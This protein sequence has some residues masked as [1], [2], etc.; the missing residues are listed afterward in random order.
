MAKYTKNDLIFLPLGGSGEIGMNVNL[1]HFKGQWIMCDLG[2]GF[3]DDRHPGVDLVVANINFVKSLGEHFLGLVCTHAHED[4]IGGIPYLWD[5]LECPIYATPF[6][7]SMVRSKLHETGLER[8]AKVT[9]VQPG[10][11]FELGP[12]N[13]ELVQIT[14]SIPE[15]NGIIIKTELGTV[16]HTGDWKLDPEPV[17]GP[18]T[19]E[20]RLKQCGDEGVLAMICDSTNIFREGTSGSESGLMAGLSGLI[21]E[22]GKGLVVVATFASNV[23][24]LDTIARAAEANGRKV[25]L[26]GRSLW[27]VYAAARENGY[28]TDLEPFLDDRQAVKVP[29]HK[30]L[31]ISTG[32][33]GEE[34]AATAKLAYGK[35]PGLRLNK[36]DTVIFSS[37]VIPGNEKKIIH[38]LNE[39]VKQRVEVYTEK[40]HFVHVSGH[41]CRDEVRRMYELVRPQ[42]AVPVHGEAMHLHEH[43]KFAKSLGVPQ[44]VEV[45]NGAMVRLAPGNAEIIQHIENGIWM[46]DGQRLVDPESKVMKARR[47]MQRSGAAFVTV[48]LTKRGK[49]VTEPQI[50]VPGLLDYDENRALLW[51]LSEELADVVDSQRQTS[52]DAIVR[53]TR[54][55][56]RKAL[57]QET[58]KEPLIEVHVVVC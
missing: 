9:E 58:G 53:A 26:A 34:Q 20:A 4:H 16:L 57:K 39:F 38:L 1:Y 17:I 14:H 32:C 49:L 37:K 15:M 51:E 19:D 45:Q 33:Q 52:E 28:L 3:A 55:F 12:F 35:H 24:R 11:Q 46:I 27:R 7:A 31:V 8:K 10:S 43:T 50:L 42:I 41:P 56:L 2:A 54:R 23:A 36:G 21:A 25:V 29:R 5:Q 30:Q 47:R 44:T 22:A 6:T 40:D 18:T 48:V 13:L